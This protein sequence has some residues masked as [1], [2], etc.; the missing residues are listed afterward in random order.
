MRLKICHRFILFFCLISLLSGCGDQA[1][2]EAEYLQRAQVS[3]EAKEFDKALIDLKSAL[4]ANPKNADARYQLA[5][6]EARKSNWPAVESAA[7]E[8]LDLGANAE[9]LLP[10]LARSLYEQGNYGELEKSAKPV[11]QMDAESRGELHAYRSLAQLALGEVSKA[12]VELDLATEFAPGTVAT[13]TARAA[14][15]SKQGEV[16]QALQIMQKTVAENPQNPDAW[17]Q[18][19]RI[20]VTLGN[21]EEAEQAF[22]K[23]IA[24]SDGITFDYLRRAHARIDLKDY[25]GAEADIAA[26]EK[27]APNFYATLYARGVLD[28]RKGDFVAAE[29]ALGQA[30]LKAPGH[31]KAYFFLGAANYSLGHLQQAEQ[32]LVKFVNVDPNSVPALYLLGTI[33]NQLNLPENTLNLLQQPL[34]A[35]QP[36]PLLLRIAG[37]A[38]LILDEPE[39]ATTLLYSALDAQPARGEEGYALGMS[40]LKAGEE[41]TALQTLATLPEEKYQLRAKMAVAHYYLNKGQFEQARVLAEELLQARPEEPTI[42]NLSGRIYLGEKDSLQAR[43]SF[44]KALALKPDYPSAAIMLAQIEIENGNHQAAKDLYDAILKEDRDNIPGMI[45]LAELALLEGREDLYLSWLKRAAEVSPAALV[46]R[47]HLIKYYLDEGNTTEAL[48]NAQTVAT[49]RPNST[50][51]ISL[52]GRVQLTIGDSE[53]AL[54]TFQQLVKMAPTAAASHVML[55]RAYSIM[56]RP[57]DAR[58]ALERAFSLQPDSLSTI[59]A[60]AT[61]EAG[62]GNHQRAL[63]LARLYQQQ[64]PEDPIGKM[65]EGDAHMAAARYEAA[66]SAYE[67]AI[68]LYPLDRFEVKLHVARTR[69][70]DTE[71]ADKRLLEWLNDH[72]EDVYVRRYLA[73]SYLKRDLTGEAAQQYERLTEIDQDDAESFN[74]LAYLYG[75]TGDKRA[76]EF[77]E[78]AY[79]LDPGNPNAAD[80]L[81]WLLT[82]NGQTTRGAELIEQAAKNS[83]SPEI[84]Y[85]WAYVS[86]EAGQTTKAREIVGKVPQ[87]GMPESL[88]NQFAELLK[89]LPP[90]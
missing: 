7:R 34:E 30:V 67:Q 2:T 13:S 17:S 51:A 66:A 81:G 68:A 69:Q 83:S 72:P 59:N 9:S 1:L 48:A 90:Q 47:A 41:E 10:L 12:E 84:L 11:D 50:E 42:H 15:L 24:N 31:Y 32:N 4:K 52:L 35:D 6:I 78:K 71:A 65:L 58:R 19:A 54:A 77:A 44:E 27:K 75:K 5:L 36:N 76:L 63:E 86:L 88:Q 87:T 29:Q 20:E 25:A 60:L 57:A 33:Y 43:K 3:I 55:A 82:Q 8:A 49:Y 28:F 45:G 46:P 74:N 80:T 21:L 79:S 64:S 16:E 26:A 40:L 85:H 89:R 39:A 73:R 61:M 23:A 14:L 22:T 37:E 38:H 56:G 18:L 62:T 53:A 70:G